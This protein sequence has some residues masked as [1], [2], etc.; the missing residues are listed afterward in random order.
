MG[1]SRLVVGAVFGVNGRT[2]AS[3]EVKIDREAPPERGE[4]VKS[5]DVCAHTGFSHDPLSAWRNFQVC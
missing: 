3:S 5:R 4:H 2:T 1:A